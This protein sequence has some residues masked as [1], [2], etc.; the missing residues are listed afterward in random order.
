MRILM[1]TPF[2]YP[3]LGGTESFIANISVKLN[4]MG[5]STDVMTFNIDQT[6]KPWSINKIQKFRVEKINGLHIIKIPALTLLPTRIMF[7]VNFIPGKFLD[8][9]DEY[10]IVHFHN[11]VDLSFPLFSY[12][13]RKPKIL[14]CHCLSITFNSYKN[15]PLHN[16]LLKKLADVYIVPS[17]FAYKLI[18][19]L[20]I[21]KKRVEIVP[22]SVDV[23]KFRPSKVDRI[24]NLLL[25]VGRLD[26]KKG[27]FVLLKALNHLK[28]RVHL[29]II[30]PP[31]RPWIFKKLLF[32]VRRINEKNVHQVTYLGVLR[33]NEVIKWYQKASIFVCP[34]L[35][36]S[37][38]I[39]NLEAL[40]CA[41]PVV[42]TDVGGIP[43]VVKH[44]ENGILVPPGDSVKLAEGI[45]YLLDNDEVRRKF[46]QQG[47]KWV[48][49]N[50]SPEK[51]AMKLCQIYKKVI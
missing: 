33:P 22:N 17:F 42:A 20:N 21:P 7:R 2:Y 11:D 26:S 39:V 40:S 32:L 43:E 10:D 36:E 48:V 23:A 45:Q 4:E 1:V 6:W 35:S 31:S 16:L 25:F 34:S 30:G 15:N 49:E 38:G 47:R 12:F 14:H 28:T 9:F 3:I 18:T 29:T 5:V 51:V 24:E 13:V 44:H 50:F 46:G 41:T 8:R 27:I 37:F 19:S